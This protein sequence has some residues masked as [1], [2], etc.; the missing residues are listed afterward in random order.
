MSRVRT[1]FS[2]PSS[3]I[4]LPYHGNRGDSGT[5]RIKILVIIVPR[6]G[7]RAMTDDA[8]DDRERDAGVGLE[9]NE[10]MPERMERRDNGLAAASINP[11]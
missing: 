10:G 3:L 2:H 11:D 9:R 4:P 6:H 5:Q 1:I 7:G 8:L